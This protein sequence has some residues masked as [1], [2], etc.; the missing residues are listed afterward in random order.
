MS[1]N[2]FFG[3]TNRV[4]M[5]FVGGLLVLSYL[6]FFLNP[7]RAWIM[8]FFGLMFV[9][10][11][12]INL[13]LLVWAIKRRSRSFL[14]PLVVIL[15]ALFF[16]NKQY[17]FPSSKSVP[18]DTQKIKILSYNVGRFSA[19]D[20]EVRSRNACVDSIFLFLAK[21]NPDIICLQEFWTP[22]INNVSD[23]LSRK[24]KR[25]KHEYF[26]YRVRN[27][28]YGNVILSKYPA[29]NKGIIKFDQSKNLAIYSDFE[30]KG[31]K[32]RVYNCHLQSYAISLPAFVKNI[33]NTDDEYFKKTETKIRAS[34]QK[35][36]DQ[37]KQILEHIEKSPL[38]TFVCGDF[39]DTPMSYTYYKLRQNREDTFV[40][41]GSGFSAT[42]S[43]F[44]PM[45]R[46][47]Y[48]LIPEEYKTLTYKSKKVS[49]SDHYPIMSEVKID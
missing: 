28:G 26:V 31:E 27:T 21:E 12:C 49:Y 15:P 30:I 47:D 29:K 22:N 24:L 16:I 42:Y 2:K 19:S 43:K 7:Q 1:S 18:E 35:R 44:W 3:F 11:V 14:I 46:I 17:Q 20:S 45:L 38:K 39:N 37:V 33:V 36:S 8:V 40:Q 41:A 48:I 32:I 4:I 25:Y 5:L 10:L 34:I 6:S 23:Y 9:P 13:G